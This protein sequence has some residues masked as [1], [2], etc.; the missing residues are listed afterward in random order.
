MHTHHIHNI[1]SHMIALVTQSLVSVVSLHFGIYLSLCQAASFYKGTSFIYLL[2]IKSG[3]PSVSGPEMSLIISPLDFGNSFFEAQ[4]ILANTYK[5]L[6]KAE[7]ILANVYKSRVDSRK[8][9]SKAEWILANAH[10]AEWILANAY[11]KPSGFSQM[12]IKPSGFSQMLI[13]SRVDSR[14]CLSKPSGFSQM[15]YHAEWI[16]ANL[17]L[18]PVDSGEIFY[19]TRWISGKLS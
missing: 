5:T 9:L 18:S 7:C 6:S 2:V 8:C 1:N 4:W 15:F 16:L 19:E 14:K 12:L 13:K 3:I 17:V 11:Q 10:Q